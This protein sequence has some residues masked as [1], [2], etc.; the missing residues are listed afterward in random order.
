MSFALVPERL[1]QAAQQTVQERLATG[2]RERL[3]PARGRG[4][5]AQR[6]VADADLVAGLAV[7]IGERFAPTFWLTVWAI[8]CRKS[9]R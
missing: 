1:D 6:V 9:S 2:E 5:D 3:H 7:E 8:S 4:V